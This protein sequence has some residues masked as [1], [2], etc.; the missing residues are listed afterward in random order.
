VV[1]VSARGRI[2]Q[3]ASGEPVDFA[4]ARAEPGDLVIAD[5]NGVAFIPAGRAAEVVAFAER[6]VARE[7]TMAAAVLAGEPVTSV[8]HDTKFPGHM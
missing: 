1:P 6:I 8:M 4:G 2:V 7:E 5:R 3:L